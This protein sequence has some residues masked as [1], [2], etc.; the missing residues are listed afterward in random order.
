[1][2]DSFYP[3]FAIMKEID[4]AFCLSYTPEE[5]AQALAHIASGELQVEAFITS[6]VALDD[7]PEAFARLADPEKDA[8]IIVLP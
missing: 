6:R 5:F 7:V 2:Q 3:S 1:V 4:L 8:K